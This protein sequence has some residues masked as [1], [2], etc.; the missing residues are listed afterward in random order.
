MEHPPLN[1]SS[2]KFDHPFSSDVENNQLYDFFKQSPTPMVILEGPQHFIKLANPP[3]ERLVQ[4]KVV[5]KTMLEA[6]SED[7]VRHLIPRLDEVYS[8]GKPFVG[9][10]V[11]LNIRNLHGE[12]EEHWVNVNYFPYFDEDGKVKGILC[13]AHEVTDQ[14]HAKIV[15][16]ES[17]A[18]FRQIAN[19]LPN[20][21]WT[22]R[23]D[24]FIDWQSDKYSEYTGLSTL[25]KYDSSVS[26][27]HPDDVHITAKKWNHSIATGEVFEVEHRMRRHTDGQYRWQLAKGLPIRDD[28]GNIIQWVGSTTDIHD[29]KMAH[30]SLKTSEE[31]FRTLANSL[32][33]II[34]TARTDGFVDWYNDWWYKYL[35]Q[36]RGTVWDDPEKQPM[37]PDDI[38]RTWLLWNE[39]LKTGKLFEIEQRFKQ[40]SSG[41]YR[42]HLVRGVPV[43]DENGKILR[44]VGANVDINDHKDLLQKLQEEKDVRERFVATLSHD[45]RTPLT[46]AKLT[47]QVIRRTFAHEEKV[48]RSSDR[49]ISN[50]DRVDSMIQDLLDAS[51]LS[52]G[53]PLPLV[54]ED[55][56]LSTVVHSTMEDLR[57]IHGNRFNVIEDSTDIKGFWDCNGIKRIIE[58]LCNN[59]IKYGDPHLPITVRISCHS[60]D[61][62][63]LSVHNFGKPIPSEEIKHLFE[64]YRRAADAH[65]TG[66]KGWGI[67]LMLVKGVVDAHNG[68]IE[69]TSK[70]EE[71]TTFSIKLPVKFT[72]SCN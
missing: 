58:N 51:R 26:P 13:D 69:V 21:L 60:K 65:T 12:I 55:C 9:R 54:C 17:E 22:A 66:K 24:G 72:S 67:G 34:W 11:P 38:S 45:L 3:Y 36:G 68:H 61:I 39:S 8:T 52:A 43:K 62:V 10:E 47:A 50:I 14:V 25:T 23:P 57:Q 40:G 37:H 16:Q 46:S 31:Q 4:R 29:L 2:K 59:A 6:F 1:D 56:E 30:E 18:R 20:I 48:M 41:K 53:E 64:P 71:G 5:G 63:D 70:K 28:H 49:I 44:W 35:G 19:T 27:L 42:W 32:P 33:L 15:I 7:E